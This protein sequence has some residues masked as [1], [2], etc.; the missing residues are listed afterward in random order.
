M[1]TGPKAVR[2]YVIFRIGAEEYGV[3]VESVTSIIRFETPT[4]VPR[5]P[6]SVIGVINLRGSVIPV[7]DLTWRFRGVRFQ[8]APTSRVLVA[9]GSHGRFGVAV[10]AAYEVAKVEAETVRP[11]PEGILSAETARAF[12]GVIDREG[13]LVILLDLDEALPHAD[14]TPSSDGVALEGE[15]DV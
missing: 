3:P 11:V 15:V 5:A 2:S 13:S 6:E 10:D 14:F 8:P 7:V 4:P 9:D 12:T 1:S